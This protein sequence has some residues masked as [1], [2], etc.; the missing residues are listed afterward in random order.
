VRK[1]QQ[2]NFA[3]S[4]SDSSNENAYWSGD[5]HSAGVGL[6][7][8]NGSPIFKSGPNPTISSSH[9]GCP[10]R[11]RNGNILAILFFLK[12]PA[13]TMAVKESGSNAQLGGVDVALQSYMGGAYL[14]VD[15]VISLTTKFSMNSREIALIAE[16]K[17]CMRGWGDRGT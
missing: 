11:A 2:M 13:A 15:S 5:I 12:E 10:Y 4:T 14:L 7:M 3:D 6:A 16:L 1:V 8:A 17:N 9:I